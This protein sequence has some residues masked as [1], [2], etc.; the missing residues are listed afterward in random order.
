M[1][2]VVGNA[3]WFAAFAFV[4]AM[5]AGMAIQGSLQKSPPNEYE[6]PT[7]TEQRQRQ[8]NVV[9]VDH[10]ASDENNKGKNK[11]QWYDNST[12]WLLVL[13]NGLLVVATIALFISAE[14]GVDAAKRSAEAAD[15]SAQIAENGLSKLQRAFIT[16]NRIFYL[17]HLGDDGTVWWS[18]HLD[19]QNSGNS[20]ARKVRPFFTRYFEDNDIPAAYKFAVPSGRPELFVGPHAGMQ[21][22]GFGIT[23]DEFKMVREG[24]KFLY[25]WGQIDYR[26]IFDGTPD[27]VTKFLIQVKD[28]RGDVTKVWDDKTNVIE[29]LM[30][31][32]GRHNCADEDCPP[33]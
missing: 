31:T 26:D 9:V 14:R 11:R 4:V 3:A 6:Q 1:L 32:P 25:I 15:R 30:D 22:G 13:F 17:S 5:I 28:F 12:D 18:A 2:K 20:P 8:N 21:S 16:I 27:H 23:A 19:W 29:V 33:E 10:N 24:K 7:K